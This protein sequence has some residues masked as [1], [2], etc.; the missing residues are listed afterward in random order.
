MSMCVCVCNT[1]YVFVPHVRRRRVGNNKLAP[2]WRVYV[3]LLFSFSVAA[4]QVVYDK[5]T[6][7]GHDVR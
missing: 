4:V 6:V 3:T 5:P 7:P 2:R 1:Y